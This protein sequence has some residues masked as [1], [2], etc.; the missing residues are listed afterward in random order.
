VVDLGRGGGWEEYGVGENEV[1]PHPTALR[2]NSR[3][4]A[5]AGFS[6]CRGRL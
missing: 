5:G 2:R 3:A 4:T 6:R 1:I